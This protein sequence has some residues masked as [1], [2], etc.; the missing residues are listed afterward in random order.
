M[1]ELYV[2]TVDQSTVG[3]NFRDKRVVLG[4]SDRVKP[5]GFAQI[6]LVEVVENGAS[7]APPTAARSWRALPSAAWR[8]AAWA[9]CWAGCRAA[10]PRTS[11]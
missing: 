4:R 5:Y 11:G 6:S 10:R 2:S 1:D 7:T 3:V 9:R 8:W